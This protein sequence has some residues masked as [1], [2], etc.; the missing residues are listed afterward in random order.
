MQQRTAA[1]QAE[2]TRQRQA[3]KHLQDAYQALQRRMFAR[4]QEIN[5]RTQQLEALYRADEELYRHLDLDE[6]LQTLTVVAVDLLQA[7]KSVVM[8]WD[9]TRQRLAVRAAYGF[10]PETLA[11]ELL[12]PEKSLAGVVAITG[13]PAVVED[14]LVDARVA[15]RITD[16][17]GIRA[18][19]HVPIKIGEQVY[20]VYNVDYLEPRTFS[21]EDQRLFMSLAQRAALAIENA[22]LYERAQYAAAAE[23]R[24]R[25]AREL[26]DA[27]TQTLF[28]ASL[29]AD[30]LPRLWERSPEQARQRLA[31]LRE[32]TR[33]A[34][35]EMR[36][37]LLELRPASLMEI[38][39]DDLLRQ[40]AEAIIGRARLPIEVQV[41]GRGDLPAEI[42][43]ALYRIAQES[44][45]NIARHAAADQ[46][47]IWLH[48]QPERVL[49]TI[50]DDG[51]GF[52]PEVVPVN[53]MGLGI[54][55]ERA[56]KIGAT[57]TIESG[58]NEG[59]QVTVVWPIPDVAP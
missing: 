22:R 24:N 17:E 53:S 56:G 38:S 7:D 16:P 4:N 19:M 55:R 9:G 48:Y 5:Q 54:M 26:H 32:L 15:R 31:E 1:L 47:Q 3:H 46:V 43:V 14:A 10:S 44:L 12:T 6:V 11:T 27:V 58:I 34:L 41:V 51:R 2:L 42:R 20:G 45:H 35:A 59:T 52:N 30:V 50:R 25:L 23:E 49:L 28:S 29:I 40:L 13:I 21:E 36:T 33:G 37:L 18:F 39:L 8:V 57:L